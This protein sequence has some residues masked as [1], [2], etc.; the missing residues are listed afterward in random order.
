MLER[1][2]GPVAYR[3]RTNYIRKKES[4]S[5]NAAAKGEEAVVQQRFIPAT[6]FEVSELGGNTLQ[7]KFKDR[8]VVH[9]SMT[10]QQGA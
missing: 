3:G 9:N 1:E 7:M 2:I 4:A 10:S 6:P 8:V 5:L